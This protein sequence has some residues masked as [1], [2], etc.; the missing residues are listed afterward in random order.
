MKKTF[1]FLAAAAALSLP[2]LARQDAPKTS[3][4]C[5]T[6]CKMADKDCSKSC[7]DHCQKAA[8]KDKADA[9]K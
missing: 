1:L 6:R 4:A 7:M 5:K 8:D 3:E 2:A 9:K